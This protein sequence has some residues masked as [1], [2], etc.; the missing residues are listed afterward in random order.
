MAQIHTKKEPRCLFW[1]VCFE[2][3]T[4]ADEDERIVELGRDHKGRLAFFAFFINTGV[5]L[6]SSRKIEIVDTGV[7]GNVGLFATKLYEAFNGS[8]FV[9]AE[10]HKGRIFE[11]NLCD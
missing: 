9:A 3:T 6:I 7:A 5:N 8:R 10:A 1:N 2:A 4:I 11:V